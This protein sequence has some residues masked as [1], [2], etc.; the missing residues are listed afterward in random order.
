MRKILVV[1][2]SEITRMEIRKMMEGAGFTVVEAS[3]GET[4]LGEV[5]KHLD[6]SVVLTD[7]SMPV[8]DGI[9]FTENLRKHSPLK[10]LPVVI[11]SAQSSP[12]HKRRAKEQNVSMWAIKPANWEM[13]TENLIKLSDAYLARPKF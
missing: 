10:E 11:L 5:E 13:I 2:D 8:M 1:E 4:A 6:L 3:C 12:D 7:L 9:K